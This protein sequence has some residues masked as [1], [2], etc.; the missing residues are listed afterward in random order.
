MIQVA[1]VVDQREAEMLVDAGVRLLGFPFRLAGHEEDLPEDEAGRIIR[2]LPAHV[3]CSLITYLSEA[4]DIAELCGE[5]G[6]SQVQLHGEI[7]TVELRRLSSVGPNL[8]VVKSLI[9]RGVNLAELEREVR[10]TAPYIHGYITDTYDPSTGA[11][12]ATGKT[13]PW[14]IDRRLVEMAPHPVM[15]AGG[16]HPGNVRKAIRQVRPA[17]VD[18]HSGIEGPDGR[19]DELL[20]RRFVAEA[21]AGFSE[22]EAGRQ[23]GDP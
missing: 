7:S 8:R 18:V 21:D 14:W 13:H 23:G 10:R 20:T 15:M 11:V 22:V 2:S 5:L 9:V 3:V 1:G 4:R 12:G 6:V 19:K 17:G 16:L